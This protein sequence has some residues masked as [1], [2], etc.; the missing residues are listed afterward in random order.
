[1]KGLNKESKLQLGEKVSKFIRRENGSSRR[2]STDYLFLAA[3][4]S[5]QV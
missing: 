2:L 3:S 4:A 1:M 5:L